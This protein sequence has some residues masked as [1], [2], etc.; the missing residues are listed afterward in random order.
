MHAL[1][2][3]DLD[4]HHGQV[5][6]V[7]GRNGSGK[8]SLLWALQGQGPRSGGSVRLDS[9]GPAARRG[10]L[11][12][13]PAD[14]TDPGAMSP[15]EAR[16]HVAL[17]P[18]TPSDL[19]YLESV[20]AE[21]RAADLQAGAAPGTAA[22]L[23]ARLVPEVPPGSHPRDLSEG[24]RLALALAVQLTAA[25]PV[26][27]LDEPTRGLDRQAKAK[28]GALLR[29]L[30]AD[31]HAVVLASHDVEFVASWANRVLV[32]GEGDLVADGSAREV[33]VASPTFAPQVAKVLHPL[34]FLTVDDVAAA[35]AAP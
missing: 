22:G 5:L 10:L 6:A 4:L 14:V 9:A 29:D 33:L 11:R 32:L 8:S 30:A 28:L 18:Q 31:G 12:R 3:V 24:Q 25:P 19:L 17:V 20:A 2:G 35:L 26:V 16:R 1:R 27:L 21:C 23:L 34:P 13:A 15:A 7:M